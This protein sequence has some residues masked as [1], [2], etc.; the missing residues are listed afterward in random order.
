MLLRAV[1]Y[2]QLGLLASLHVLA[3]ELPVRTIYQGPPGVWFENLRVRQNGSILTTRLDKPL[4]QVV[5]PHSGQPPQTVHEFSEY[6]GLIGITET[7]PDLFAVA[8]GNFTLDTVVS[9]PGTYAIW[10]VDYR[11]QSCDEHGAPLISKLADVPTAAFLNG[12]TY[13]PS[14]HAILIADSELGL[15]FNMDLHTGQYD[16]AVNDSLTNKCG[17]D[18]LEGINGIKYFNSSLYWTNSGCGWFAKVRVDAAGYPVEDASIVINPDINMD[19]FAITRD[20]TAYLASGFTNQV[21]RLTPDGQF[22][23]VAGNRNSS[24]VAEPVALTVGRTKEDWERGTLYV[25][26]GGALA[27]PINGTTVIGGQILALDTKSS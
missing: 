2:L 15:I 5:D 17:A 12:L 19:D 23:P 24:E 1:L 10:T 16:V 22:G 9:T 8:A 3:Q 7:E 18:Q 13:I 25:S 11:A 4:L 6:L 14:A 21:L 27:D 20:G 26:T